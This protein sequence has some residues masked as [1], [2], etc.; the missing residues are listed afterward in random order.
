MA[1]STVP[2]CYVVHTECG[3]F[4]NNRFHVGAGTILSRILRTQVAKVSMYQHSSLVFKPRIKYVA[5]L[6]RNTFVAAMRLPY[7]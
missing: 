1:Y 3:Y 4:K 7:R 2:I 6:A 5:S